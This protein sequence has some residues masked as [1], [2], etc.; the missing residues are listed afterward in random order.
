MIDFNVPREATL[1][2]KD[3]LA[4]LKVLSPALRTYLF[5]RCLA[6][7]DGICDLNEVQLAKEIGQCQRAVYYQ[8]GQLREHGL[9][10]KERKTPG[11]RGKV[12]RLADPRQRFP[13]ATLRRKKLKM[14][15]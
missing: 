12:F 6:D 14:A 1:V 3:L 9:L 4:D 10:R 2:T 13:A 7:E 8:L 5:M 15:S 11:S